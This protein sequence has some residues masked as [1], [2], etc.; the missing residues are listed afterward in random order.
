MSRI[1]EF[2]FWSGWSS[3]KYFFD[4][5]N[6]YECLKQQVS[7]S[8]NHIKMHGSAFEQFTGLHDKNGVKIFEGDIVQCTMK[9]DGFTLPHVGEIIYMDSFG[10]F[11][12]KNHAGET[13]LHNHL[14][15]TFFII[16]NIHQHQ[17]LLEKNQ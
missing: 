3:K 14:L 17:H 10:A 1:I 16:G 6:V 4:H 11:A 13:L 2:R 15:N 12:T 5:Q 7:G 8:Y 9:C